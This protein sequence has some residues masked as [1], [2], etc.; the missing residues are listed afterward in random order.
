MSTPVFL[1]MPEWQ[2][3]SSSRAMQLAEG[4][5]TLRED[6]PASA[7]REVPVPLEAGDAMGT[8]VARLSS[9]L[10]ARAAA[11]ETLAGVEEGGVPVI[12]GGD[13]ASSL[14]GLESAVRRHGSESL[15]VLWFDAHPDLQHPSTSPSG[16]A[17]GMTLRHALGDGAPDLASTAPIDPSLL[18]LI[19]TREIDPEEQD[20]LR[21]LGVHVLDPPTRAGGAPAAPTA[22][23]T[24]E[25]AASIVSRLTSSAATRVYV[26]VDLDVL[27]P[28]EFAAVHQ[29]VPFGLAVGQ[30]TA[31]IRAAVAL[32]PLAGA[33]ICEFAPADPAVAADDVPTVLRILA[34]LTSGASA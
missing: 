34:A 20:E 8:P 29:A 5:G 24:G 1:V 18:T 2:G 16:A 3:S 17:S 10:R 27:D 19:G 7:T 14:P 13:C 23:H 12:V 22:P 31:A 33:S 21:R 26:H 30:L 15:A 4:A 9:L 25:L 11:L 32:L 6:L 28:A